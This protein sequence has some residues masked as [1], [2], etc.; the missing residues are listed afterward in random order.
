MDKVNNIKLDI[1]NKVKSKFKLQQYDINEFESFSYPKYINLFKFNTKQYKIEKLGNMCILEGSSILGL[2]LL[3]VVFT[4]NRELDIPFVIIDFVE[5]RNKSTVFVEFYN[6]HMKNKDYIKILD[7]KLSD[8]K[9]KYESIEDYMENPKW[10][11]PLRDKYSPLKKGSKE[12]KEVL[13]NMVLDYLDEYINFVDSVKKEYSDEKNIELEKFIDDLIV[14][15]NPS[16]KI[17]KK[18]LGEDG[19]NKFCREIIFKY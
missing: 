1:V 10:Y 5:V 16:S 12:N 14:K 13:I 11:T 8:K 17:L 7:N 6:E 4:P 18:A 19:Y 15:G 9:E 2:S 3:T